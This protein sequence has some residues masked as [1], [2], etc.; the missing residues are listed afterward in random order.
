VKHAFLVGTLVFVVWASAA[1][2]RLVAQASKKESATAADW[3]QYRGP[4]R[5]GISPDTGLLKEWPS[6]GPAVVWKATGLGNGYSSISISGKHIYTMGDLSG[7]CC[8]VALNVSDGKI[9]WQS[10]ISSEFKV[11]RPGSRSTPAT[12]GKLVF[13]LSPSGD[14]ACVDAAKGTLVWSKNLKKDFGGRVGGWAYSESPLLDGMAVVVTP[15]SDSK[16]TVAALN[17]T[18][19]SVLWQ[20]AELKDAAEYTS[21]VPA[22]FG[23]VP[24]YVVFTQHSVAGI[25][26][27]TGKVL[28]RA[29][30]RG[31][32]AVIPTPVVSKDGFVFVTSGYGVGHNAFRVAAAGGRFQV[33]EVY[34]GKQLAV[35]T[36]AIILI[37]D[38]VYGQDDGGQLRCMDLKTGKEAW[39]NRSVGGKGTLACADGMLVVRNEQGEVALVDANPESYKE[40]GRFKSERNGGDQGWAHPVIFGGKLYIRDWDTLTCYDLKGKP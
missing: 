18:N 5:D 10:K 31:S 4:N 36:G 28:W 30:R 39:A 21:L 29:D 12:D 25:H 17:K 1:A 34:S 37:G 32:T 8:I 26:S 15:G 2:P 7:S 23:G 35:H 6:S 13:S 33:S 14:L 38:H 27:K 24:Q 22:D 16:G 9:A 3:Y 19:G 20:S 11:D 40:K